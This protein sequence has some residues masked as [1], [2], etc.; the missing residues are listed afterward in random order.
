[1]M[2]KNLLNFFSGARSGRPMRGCPRP[3]TQST[4]EENTTFPYPTLCPFNVSFLAPSVLCRSPTDGNVRWCL[5]LKTEHMIVIITGV[6]TLISPRLRG[7]A[8]AKSY[9]HYSRNQL[10]C[11][12][13]HCLTRS[14][15]V[16]ASPAADA[17]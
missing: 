12:R 17:R 1:M 10:V 4:G 15:S 9:E 3:R 16:V 2:L 6:S 14:G 11:S 13:C 5:N 7:S 8:A